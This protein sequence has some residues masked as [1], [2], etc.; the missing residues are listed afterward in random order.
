MHQE[1]N[2][3]QMPQLKEEW[4]ERSCPRGLLCGSPLIKAHE[5][6]NERKRDGKWQ[7]RDDRE[8]AGGGE[9]ALRSERE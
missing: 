7:P 4:K 1:E 2:E 3:N 6:Q 5:E 8:W 9:G